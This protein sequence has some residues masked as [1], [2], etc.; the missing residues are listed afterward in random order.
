WMDPPMIYEANPTVIEE[1]MVLF[2]HMI[3]AD[4]SSRTAM[5]LGRSYIATR[6]GPV[7]LSRH[8][9]DLIRC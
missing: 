1:N 8:E 2:H 7:C 9:I 3:I 5:T 4:S 6:K